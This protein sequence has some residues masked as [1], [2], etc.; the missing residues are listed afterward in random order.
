MKRSAI[1]AAY[2]EALAVFASAGRTLPPKPRWDITDCGSGDFDLCGIVLVNL[3]D[4]PEYAEKLI[5]MREGQTIPLHTHGRKKEDIICHRGLLR[6]ELW[7]GRPG[8]RPEGEPFLVKI[9]G[10]PRPVGNGRPF[11]LAAGERATLVPGV[12]HR[13]WPVAPGSVI[14]EV[15]TA[16][17]DAN[18]NIFLDANVVRFPGVEEDE[19]AVIRLL[20]DR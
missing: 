16:N 9:N 15:S 17:D 20:S 7:L 14:G 8:E 2:H 3:A 19:P 4:E 5:Y 6:M 1:N 10:E 18:D 13:F 11:D 12:Y